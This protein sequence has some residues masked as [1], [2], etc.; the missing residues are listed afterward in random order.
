[1]ESWQ[2]RM[3]KDFSGLKRAGKFNKVIIEFKPGGC[4][5]SYEIPP[6]G[7]RRGDWLLYLTDSQM[8]VVKEKLGLRTAISSINITP[9]IMKSKAVIFQQ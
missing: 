6:D 4:P 3:A 8:A 2:Q 5:A 7:M 9:D 1:M